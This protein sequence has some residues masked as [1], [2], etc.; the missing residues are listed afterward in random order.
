MDITPQQLELVQAAII[1]PHNDVVLVEEFGIPITRLIAK[2][3]NPKTWFN[4]ELINFYMQ[5]LQQWDKRL[6]TIDSVR[7]PSHIFNI[8]F[9]QKLLE[10]E[11]YDYERVKRFVK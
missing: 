10:G 7:R 8:Y 6:C 9:M 2:R 11:I 1:P 5:L 4:D 3:I